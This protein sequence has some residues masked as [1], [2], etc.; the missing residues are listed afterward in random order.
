MTQRKYNCPLCGTEL[1][2]VQHVVEYATIKEINDEGYVTDM[3][4]DDYC[5]INH[6]DDGVRCVVCDRGFSPKELMRL[7]NGC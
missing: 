5:D 7:F 6:P 1:T 3:E 4:V 2:Y